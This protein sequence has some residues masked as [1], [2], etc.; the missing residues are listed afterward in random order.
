LEDPLI[1]GNSFL[2]NEISRTI[3]NKK[4]QNDLRMVRILTSAIKRASVAVNFFEE[5]GMQSGNLLNKS[6]WGYLGVKKDAQ[7]EIIGKI[8][9][10]L[11]IELVPGIF[12]VKTMDDGEGTYSEIDDEF[13]NIFKV[14]HEIAADEL[15][16][17][18]SYAALKNDK[19][20]NSIL[21]MLADLSREF[22]FDV[23]IWY[24]NHKDKADSSSTEYQENDPE[25]YAP[26]YTVVAV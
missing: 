22:L 24:L 3:S 26:E 18:L 13:E 12:K 11:G 7:Q 9:R 1:I 6:F 21:L 5:R 8:A 14:I 2:E 20:T 25:E 19:K 15:E 17:Y 4:D 23:K 16:F 10:S